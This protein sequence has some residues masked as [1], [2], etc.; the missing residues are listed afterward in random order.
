METVKQG[1]IE[2]IQ[3]RVKS[4]VIEQSNA[5]LLIKLI[6]NAESI[7]EAMSIAE[8]GT[9]YKRTGYYFDVRL[10]KQTQKI[11]Y[12]NRN[13]DL[14]I[15]NAKGKGNKLIIGDNFDALNNLLITHRNKID[16]IYIDPPYGK[17]SMGNFADTNYENGLTRDN[18]LSMLQPRLILAKELLT[19][20]GVIFCSI[21]DRNQAHVKLLFDEVFGEQN[22]IANLIYKKK[23][24]G[25]NDAK[26]VSIEHEYIISYQKENSAW[27][28][29]PL[30]EKRSKAYKYEDSKIKT[31][32]KYTL[33]DLQ[34]SSLKDSK[35]LHYDIVCPDGSILSG[36]NNQWKCNLETFNSRLKD[37]R[38]E[39]RTKK[40]GEWG[41]YYKIYLN[42]QNGVLLMDENGNIKQKGKNLSSLI[43]DTLNTA[44][45]SELKDIFNG[46]IFDN[47]KSKKLIKTL[48]S[49]CSDKNAIILD[50]FAG[51]GT[52][53][54]AVL[55]LNKEDGGNRTFILCT[56]N[57]I[58][59]TN[60]KGIAYDVTAKR[61]KRV[62]TGCCYDGSKDFKWIDNN[63]PYGGSMDVFEIEEIN[64]FITEGKPTPFDVIDEQN[65]GLDK[66][67]NIMSK[68]DWVCENFKST[69]KKIEKPSVFADCEGEA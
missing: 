34:D 12:L 26:G 31:H 29:L 59:Q 9:M 5:D 38:I 61:M 16:V 20:E 8:L 41:C 19:D 28:K 13:N 17:D 15:G 46:S 18:L 44:G 52:T 60:P 65:Y 36:S 22:F 48:I 47:P 63:E 6:G 3:A 58:T 50:F 56:N 45:S 49:I 2:D 33:K 42:E 11:K 57:E 67:D 27:G 14:S 4:R 53:G 30:S 7:Q 25:S 62:M 66:F 43:L 51:S 32:G 23:A 37:K 1:L 64:N 69:C 24:G 54:Q 35:G 39:F 55:D 21:D 40:N 68:A 10:E